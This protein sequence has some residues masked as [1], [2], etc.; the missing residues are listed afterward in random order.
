MCIS[1]E[2]LPAPAD[3][4]FRKFSGRVGTGSGGQTRKQRAFRQR[5]HGKRPARR[6][7]G[8]RVGLFQRDEAQPDHVSSE[9]VI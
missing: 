3:V 4:G 1:A 2:R 9:I 7:L 6:A 8:L 5:R